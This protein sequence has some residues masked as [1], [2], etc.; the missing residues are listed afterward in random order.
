MAR[1]LI[2]VVVPVHK[3][4]MLTKLAINS[5][6]N[7]TLD[8]SVYEVIV[9]SN[10]NIP[11]MTGIN[12]LMSTDRWLGP[13]L[14]DGVK[15][16]RGDIV[17]FLDYDD[18]FYPNKLARVVHHFSSN[19]D[20]VFYWN[21]QIFIDEYGAEIVPKGRR[22]SFRRRLINLS[23]VEVGELKTYKLIRMA[24]FNA[25]SISIKKEVIAR[26]TAKLQEVRISS[27]SPLMIAAVLNGGDAL[28]DDEPL[29]KYRAHPYATDPEMYKAYMHDYTMFMHWLG[30]QGNNAI[31]KYL[32]NYYKYL[33]ARS[34]LHHQLY[35]KTRNKVRAT[36]ALLDCIRYGGG[37]MDSSM[38]LAVWALTFL[39]LPAPLRIYW[40]LGGG[41]PLV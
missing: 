27:D 10:V 4:S 19:K 2:S 30:E 8:R 23:A 24:G 36:R 7:Q 5:A 31:S 28:I 13:K 40:K 14:A 18:L 1:P 9:V 22:N 37:A 33:Y 3:E 35:V 32:K 11:E 38:A 17:A 20:L 15:A 21:K 16:A 41:R 34:E 39:D 26:Y 29:T 25:S 6:L 12:I